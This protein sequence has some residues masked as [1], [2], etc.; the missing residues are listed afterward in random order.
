MSSFLRAQ[1][2]KRVGAPEGTL[3][4]VVGWCLGRQRSIWSGLLRGPLSE[5]RWDVMGVWFVCSFRKGVWMDLNGRCPSDRKDLQSL[6]LSWDP[7][8]ASLNP[9]QKVIEPEENLKIVWSITQMGKTEAQSKD[10]PWP[11]VR[12]EMAAR[13][14]WGPQLRLNL[15]AGDFG[16]EG[17]LLSSSQ[18][19]VRHSHPR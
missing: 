10:L 16:S 11:R 13:N 1:V 12:R 8:L 19:G 14:K 7:H 2:L 9:C 3:D 17:Y 6:F 5:S 4:W 18:K 15:H